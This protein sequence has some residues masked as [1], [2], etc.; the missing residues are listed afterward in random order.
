MSQNS[1]K[2]YRFY[3]IDLLRFLAA[4]AVV[5]YHYTFRGFIADDM[6][7]VEFPYLSL[8]SRYGYLG[9]EL[10]FMIS[11]FVILLTARKRS[12]SSF[13]I[14]RVVRLYP[15]YWACVSLTFIVVLLFGGMQYDA[16]FFQYLSNLTMIHTLIGVDS[17]DGVYWTLLVELRFYFIIFLILVIRQIHNVK[18][19][20]GL[21][22]VSSIILSVQPGFK[23]FE[24]ILI[25]IWSA[26]FVAG[27]VFYL[28]RQEGL[29]LYKVV[30]ILV[31]YAT[32]LKHAH[33]QM[34]TLTNIYSSDFNFMVIAF[35]LTS[36][37]VSFSLI[38]I[39][40]T[41]GIAKPWFIYVG[42]LTYP[43]YLVHQNIGF[44]L[45]NSLY[46]YMNRYVLLLLVFVTM[47]VVSYLIHLRIEKRFANPFKLLLEKASA[48]INPLKSTM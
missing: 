44:I 45:F 19:F 21:W 34:L 40:K 39:G 48:T 32:S 14:S 10:F 41:Q 38:A 9:V 42:V 22:L 47:I 36:F 30:M 23:I 24:F 3:E 7:L 18:F 27:A 33:V 35:I 5:M 11:G 1:E 37:Y 46:T 17:I 31:C 13:I 4:F 29:S 6:S 26:Y 2:R 16:S 28:I 15:V 20:L 43:L 25:P 8:V 12:V